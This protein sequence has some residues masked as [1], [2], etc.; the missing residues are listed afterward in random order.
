[1]NPMTT[2]TT[3]TSPAADTTDTIARLGAAAGRARTHY[4]DAVDRADHMASM[5]GYSD[6]QI[7][8][9]ASIVAEALT[10][11]RDAE[12]AFSQ[13]YAVERAGLNMGTQSAPGVVFVPLEEY[14]RRCTIAVPVP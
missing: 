4:W 3:G 14:L 12:T 7:N 10:V 11:W 1:M 9:Q 2:G 6:E 5:P 13:A 8:D